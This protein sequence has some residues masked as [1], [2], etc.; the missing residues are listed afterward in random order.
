MKLNRHLIISSLACGSLIAGDKN[1]HVPEA[2]FRN[3][4]AGVV[5]TVDYREKD[6]PEIRTRVRYTTVFVLPKS[7]KIMDYVCGDKD[8]WVI[9]GADSFAYV[10]PEKEKA[11]TNLNLV[12]ASGNVYSFVLVEGEQQPDLKV[13]IQPREESM[14]SA[15][16]APARWVPA[17]DVD[18]LRQQADSAREQAKTAQ[19]AAAKSISEQV[20]TF[21]SAYPATLKHV[22]RFTDRKPFD[23]SA[24]AHDDKFTYIWAKPQEVPALY[25]LRDGKPNLISFQFR[26]GVYVVDKILDGGYLTVGKRRLEFRREE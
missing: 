15:A 8:N 10:K 11:R 1:M 21:R 3:D 23:V 16:S 17:A 22:Y 9:N 14:I 18:K 12:T 13:F 2:N 25:E 19:E 4:A 6:I 5:L 26:N 24:I 7:E 20:G